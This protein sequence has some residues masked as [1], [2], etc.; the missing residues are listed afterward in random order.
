MIPVMDAKIM[1][2]QIITFGMINV[3]RILMG[4]NHKKG[5]ASILNH[6]KNYVIVGQI[7]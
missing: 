6:M 3:L 4:C 7:T 5:K 2:I 1:Q